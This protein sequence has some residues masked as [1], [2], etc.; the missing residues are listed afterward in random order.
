MSEVKFLSNNFEVIIDFEGDLR[1]I[2]GIDDKGKSRIW[3]K[4]QSLL[5]YNDRPAQYLATARLMAS[6]PKLLELLKT[7]S[8]MHRED[9]DI[10]EVSRLVEYIENGA[11]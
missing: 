3:F 9:V 2:G 6:S 7:L 11:K 4:T 1:G 8:Y 5:D 10:S